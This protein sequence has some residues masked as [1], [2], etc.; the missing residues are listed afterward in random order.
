MSSRPLVSLSLTSLLKT[1]ARALFIRIFA[2]VFAAAAAAA[3]PWFASQCALVK[4]CLSLFVH[5]EWWPTN[6]GK[7]RGMIWWSRLCLR[8]FILPHELF[9]LYN[10]VKIPCHKGWF[11][12]LALSPSL[13]LFLPHNLYSK[14]NNICCGPRPSDDNVLYIQKSLIFQTTKWPSTNGFFSSSTRAYEYSIVVAKIS[15]YTNHVE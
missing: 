4:A 2:A 10:I 6:V 5:G 15:I 11:L 12:P 3:A 9:L 14:D 7:W 13:T 1:I 8:R